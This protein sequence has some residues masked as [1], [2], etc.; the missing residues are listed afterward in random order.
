[1]LNLIS[2]M[3]FCHRFLVWFAVVREESSTCGLFIVSHIL[4]VTSSS[5]YF[6][7]KMNESASTWNKRCFQSGKTQVTSTF[8][9]YKTHQ[10]FLSVIWWGWTYCTKLH[11]TYQAAEDPQILRSPNQIVIETFDQFLHEKGQKRN[12]SSINNCCMFPT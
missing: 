8:W 12:P 2:T 7:A 6:F 9:S 3:A 10:I 1:M 4:R 5:K 11:S